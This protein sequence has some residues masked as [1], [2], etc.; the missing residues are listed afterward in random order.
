MKP[1]FFFR[2]NIRM[3]STSVHEM[4][5]IWSKLND[6]YM[7]LC[8]LYSQYVLEKYMLKSTLFTCTYLRKCD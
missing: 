5:D 2:K 4:C 1:V 6:E 3:T 8:E 7:K